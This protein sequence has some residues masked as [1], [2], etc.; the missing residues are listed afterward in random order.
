M[1]RAVLIALACLALLPVGR[2][3]EPPAALRAVIAGLGAPEYAARETAV[4]ALRELGAQAPEAVIEEA[5]TAYLATGDPEV[6]ARLRTVLHDLVIAHRFI[7][8]QGHLGVVLHPVRLPVTVG[9]RTAYPLRVRMILPQSAAAA[10][11]LAEGDV[12]VQMDGQWLERRTRYADLEQALRQ[13]RPGDK[14]TV[15]VLRGEQVVPLELALVEPPP[16]PLEI[17]LEERREAFFDRWFRTE[18]ERRQAA[19]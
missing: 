14:L 10:G 6:K 5:M 18:L 11:G 15:G 13:R 1:R 4:Q 8:K 9:Q 2:A 7:E 19:P 12:I 17:P 3:A 16:S